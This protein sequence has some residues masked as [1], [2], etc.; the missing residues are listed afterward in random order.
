M[1]ADTL[2]ILLI[3]LFYALEC[4]AW[5]RRGIVYF[6]TLSG[7]KWRIV[8]PSRLLE[9]SVS[10]VSLLFPFPPLG[11]QAPARPPRVAF[12][13]EGVAVYAPESGE[14]GAASAGRGGASHFLYAEIERVAAR[15]DEVLVN[16]HPFLR[17]D[18]NADAAGIAELVSRLKVARVK[19]R[20]RLIERH[21]RSLFDREQIGAA[22]EDF[23]NRTDWL[24]LLTNFLWLGLIA[25]IPVFLYI[26]GFS[27]AV[28]PLLA[29]VVVLHLAVTGLTLRARRLI[30]GKPDPAILYTLLPS[31]F[32]SI[33]AADYL[34]KRLLA[35]YHPFA[36][37]AALLPRD[38]FVA[39]ARESL[40]RIRHPRYEGSGPAGAVEIDRWYK[41]A[42]IRE[43]ESAVR[44]LGFDLESL[45]RP[46]PAGRDTAY[47]TFCPRCLALY[48]LDAGVCPDCGDME[49]APLDGPR[50]RPEN[51]DRVG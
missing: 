44:D 14:P 17:A 32:H 15:G 36:V 49:L 25:G 22:V 30:Y 21:I 11:I 47:S 29:L 24:V 38:K 35:P 26:Y 37:A 50:K 19:D 33:R 13:P 6:R 8:R 51:M 2:V 27:P 20:E 18:S 40:A 43:M 12:S 31:P 7:T 46:E 48:E 10:G 23:K 34:A 45:A 5:D 9:N 28:V 39:Y 4:L 1:P 16:G 3:W 41:H 42:L